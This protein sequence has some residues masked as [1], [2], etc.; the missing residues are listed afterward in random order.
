LLAG[1]DPGGGTMQQKR[2]HAI[3][4]GRVQG[5]WFRDH[6][7]KEARRLG[8]VGWVRNRIDGTVEIIAQGEPEQIDALISWLHQGS[9]LAEVERVE[10][11]EEPVADDLSLFTILYS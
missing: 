7:L 10:W 9:P 1:H 5:V 8:L 2:I 4:H 11:W 3:V 6:T